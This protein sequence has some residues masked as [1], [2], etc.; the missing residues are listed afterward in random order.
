MMST[1]T[2]SVVFVTTSSAPS[3]ALILTLPVPV[4]VKPFTESARAWVPVSSTVCP[5]ASLIVLLLSVVTV[6]VADTPPRVNVATLPERDIVMSPVAVPEN[7]TSEPVSVTTKVGVGAGALLEEPP[8]PAAAAINPPRPNK[9]SKL[10]LLLPEDGGVTMAS[11]LLSAELAAGT[12]ACAIITFA[13][14]NCTSPFPPEAANVSVAACPSKAS[15]AA[16]NS[17]AASASS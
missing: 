16:C 8:P 4:N 3:F 1:L 7:V 17:C 11:V 5:D 6:V 14:A 9:P 2:K 12:L 15:C 13:C 10:P